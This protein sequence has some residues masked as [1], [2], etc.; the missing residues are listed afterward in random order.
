[1][2]KAN[3]NS[4]PKTLAPNFGFNSL[5]FISKSCLNFWFYLA[6]I[7]HGTYSCIP[8]LYKAIHLTKYWKLANIDILWG[9]VLWSD[10]IEFFIFWHALFSAAGVTATIRWWRT[11][12]HQSTR[13][14][15]LTAARGCSKIWILIISLHSKVF[16]I[17]QYLQNYLCFTSSLH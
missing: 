4:T 16:K 2:T 10:E 13:S 8:I 6:T 14:P 1:M 12:R 5:V 15:V 9:R 11:L 7:W 17:F 3:C